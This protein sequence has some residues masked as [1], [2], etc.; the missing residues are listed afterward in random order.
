MLTFPLIVKAPQYVVGGSTENQKLTL[1]TT[2]THREGNSTTGNS[3]TT[4]TATVDTPVAAQSA[5]SMK[6]VVVKTGSFFTGGNGIP[7][8]TDVYTSKVDFPLL[9]GGVTYSL[10]TIEETGF[11]DS[12]CIGGK[13]FNTCFVTNLFAPDVVYTTGFLTKTIRVHP[14]N[15]R[16]GAANKMA[17]VIWEYKAN[18]ASGN[19]IG[20]WILIGQCAS[21]PGPTSERRSMSGRAGQVLHVKQSAWL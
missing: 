4:L 3:I 5:T 15:F 9:E 17:T 13:H 12:L 11:A 14:N 2:S 10:V 1:S 18:D 7:K 8:S 16:A 19:P 21:G 6:S 20:N